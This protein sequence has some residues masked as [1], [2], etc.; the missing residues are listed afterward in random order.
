MYHD[1]ITPH[2]IKIP[3][4]AKVD[5]LDINFPLKLFDIALSLVKL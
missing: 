2:V 1:F 3:T 4:I 5:Y